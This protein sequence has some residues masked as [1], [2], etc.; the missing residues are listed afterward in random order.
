MAK[1][2]QHDLETLTEFRNKL[3]AGKCTSC[4]NDVSVHVSEYTINRWT[5]EGLQTPEPEFDRQV[6]FIEC[7][8]CNASTTQKLS[9]TPADKLDRLIPKI[10]SRMS[11]MLAKKL[12]GELDG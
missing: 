1:R 6:L 10:E 12:M 5:A 7:P 8:H 9:S 4:G 11:K 2:H 3:L